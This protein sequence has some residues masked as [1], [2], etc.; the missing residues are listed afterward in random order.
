[1]FFT[2]LMVTIIVVIPVFHLYTF[3]T[4]A[5]HLNRYPNY[6][7]IF[8]LIL[9]GTLFIYFVSSTA[10]KKGLVQLVLLALAIGVMLVK[11]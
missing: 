2:L 4:E 11:M 9:T 6:L 10:M 3:F 8:W 1:M 7:I 5:E